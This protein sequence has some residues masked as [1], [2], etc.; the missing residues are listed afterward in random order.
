MMR[1][2]AKVEG[3]DAIEKRVLRFF[4]ICAYMFPSIA[5]C[6]PMKTAKIASSGVKKN[7]PIKVARLAH[8]NNALTA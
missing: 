7:D 1:F 8:A 3:M 4:A 6:E 5:N 2:Q